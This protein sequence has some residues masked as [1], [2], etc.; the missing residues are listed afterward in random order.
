MQEGNAS[1]SIPTF[2]DSRSAVREAYGRN[3]LKDAA[4]DVIVSSLAENTQKQYN[5]AFKMWWNFCE[6]KGLNPYDAEDEAILEFLAER[7]N[8]GAAYG[9]LITARSAIC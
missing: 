4:L 3:G 9:T 6:Q 2:V 5:S 1:V 7:F 8:A